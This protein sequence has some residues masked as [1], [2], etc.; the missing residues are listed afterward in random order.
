V[1]HDYYDI[2][3]GEIRAIAPLTE[4]RRNMI[5]SAGEKEIQ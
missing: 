2:S 5:T 4:R 3:I 1:T